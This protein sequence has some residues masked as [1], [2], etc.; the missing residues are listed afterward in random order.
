VNA[1]RFWRGVNNHAG[2]RPVLFGADLNFVA[3]F[4][5]SFPELTFL[6]ISNESWQDALCPIDGV[7]AM[8]QLRSHRGTLLGRRACFGI[9]MH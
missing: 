4:V 1:V 5:G 8:D 6:G 3:A 9:A 2:L 7:C